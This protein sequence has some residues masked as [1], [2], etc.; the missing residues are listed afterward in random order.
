MPTASDCTFA[1]IDTY[2]DYIDTR[3]N[4]TIETKYKTLEEFQPIFPIL[5]ITELFGTNFADIWPYCWDTTYE[6]IVYVRD[7]YINA[8][9]DF[10]TLLISYLFT[11]MGYALTYRRI[12]TKI[13]ENEQNQQYEANYAQY[14]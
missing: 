9:R 12:I 7:L 14:G 11:Q 4:L 13:E 6:F 1:I 10:N 2:D 3:N 8:N 5:K